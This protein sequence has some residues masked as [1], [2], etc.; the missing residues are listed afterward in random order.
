MFSRFLNKP[1]GLVHNSF[2]K[3]MQPFLLEHYGDNLDW[4]KITELHGTA[5]ERTRL[6][7]FNYISRSSFLLLFKFFVFLLLYDKV[8]PL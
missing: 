6:T 4:N 7:Y 3:T 2:G 1:M 5:E 8:L